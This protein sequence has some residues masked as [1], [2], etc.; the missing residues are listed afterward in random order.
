[1]HVSYF[2]IIAILINYPWIIFTFIAEYNSLV[3][4]EYLSGHSLPLTFFFTHYVIFHDNGISTGTIIIMFV[5]YTNMYVFLTMT[6]ITNVNGCNIIFLCIPMHSSIPIIS[7][8]AI[9]Y[10]QLSYTHQEITYSWALLV[11]IKTDMFLAMLFSK[12]CS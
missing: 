9:E 11:I 10:T 4:I 5:Q 1:M 2:D 3:F 7:Y 12:Q 6:D 8:I